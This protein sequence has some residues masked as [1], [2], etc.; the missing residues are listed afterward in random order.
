VVKLLQLCIFGGA[1]LTIEVGSIILMD[2]VAKNPKDL[3]AAV[4]GPPRG[5]TI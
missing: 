3:T 1:K 5:A 2:G 4:T